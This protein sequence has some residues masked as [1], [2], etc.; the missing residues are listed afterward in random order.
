MKKATTEFQRKLRLAALANTPDNTQDIRAVR[1]WQRA[2][3]QAGE[4]LWQDAFLAGVAH[5]MS[6]YPLDTHEIEG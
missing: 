3:E 2:L 4:S 5:T 1:M 6:I